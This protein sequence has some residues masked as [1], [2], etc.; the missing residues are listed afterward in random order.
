MQDNVSYYDFEGVKDENEV[1]APP[2]SG[3][4]ARTAADTPEGL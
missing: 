2:A 3:P 1:L 4:R